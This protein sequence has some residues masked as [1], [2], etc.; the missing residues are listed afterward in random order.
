[1]DSCATAATK[2]GLKKK[3]GRGDQKDDKYGRKKV[4][5]IPIKTKKVRVSWGNA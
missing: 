3:P 2:K 1:M 4:G 5:S